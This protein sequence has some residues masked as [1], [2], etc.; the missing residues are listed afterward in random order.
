VQEARAVNRAGFFHF[1]KEDSC[2]SRKGRAATRPGGSR[3][4]ATIRM[5]EMLD[6]Q[7]EK[8]VKKALEL[9]MEG[10][11]GALRLCVERIL[12]ARKSE[13]LLCTMPRIAKAGDAVDAVASIASAATAG[14]VSADQAAKLAKVISVY[15]D[16]LEAYEFDERLAKLERADFKGP[17]A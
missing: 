6:E 5:Q 16:S 10:S 14:E 4:K 15:L 2:N 3:N 12:P 13:P 7:A 11:V 17:A 9:A 8:L 1:T